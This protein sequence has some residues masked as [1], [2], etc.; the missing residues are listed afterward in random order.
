MADKNKNKRK[1]NDDYCAGDT[2]DEKLSA[3]HDKE[4]QAILKSNRL[5]DHSVLLPSQHETA[6]LS[7]F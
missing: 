6:K 1:V 4:D 2:R 3:Q 5:G 7:G